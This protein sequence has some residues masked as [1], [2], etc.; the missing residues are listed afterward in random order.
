MTKSLSELRIQIDALDQDLLGMINRRA[1]LA[2]EVGEIKRIEG[3][4]HEP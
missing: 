2:H 3:K 1:A 4:N